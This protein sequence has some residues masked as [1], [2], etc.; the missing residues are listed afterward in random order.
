VRKVANNKNTWTNTFE[1]C[2]YEWLNAF[3]GKSA[4]RWIIY[5]LFALYIL[6]GVYVV[7]TDE[8]GVLKRFGRVV[9]AQVAPGIHYHFP[10]P[11]DSVDIVKVK[12]V[13][14]LQVG[15]FISQEQLE[16][17]KKIYGEKGVE[18]AAI[19]APYCMTGDKNL[20][21]VRMI[22]QYT[23]R[24]PLLYL[25]NISQQERLLAD[26]MNATI[27]R[28]IAG[29]D[30]DTVLTVGKTRIQNMVRQHGQ[31]A[32]DAIGAGI[33][34]VACELKQAEPPEYVLPAFRDVI[35][36]QVDKNT[37]IH[38][39]EAYA[40]KI[41]PEARGEASRIV[42]EAQAY[43]EERIAHA[44]GESQRFLELLAKYKEAPE[45]TRARLFVEVMEEVLPKT[46]KYIVPEEGAVDLNFF[47]AKDTGEGGGKK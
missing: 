30:V 40:N 9:D 14:R 3:R 13:K 46:K 29:L 35:N 16:Q 32:L 41:I 11:V 38:E 8:V 39:A 7:D 15:F 44:Q 4:W 6:S 25:Y 19:A 5:A 21:Y 10:F 47:Q 2:R 42:Q 43:K 33:N 37:K 28:V 27:L 18:A 24:D 12:E 36:A 26:I 22:V 23:V 1:S 20:I 17:L 34:I 31:K 45:I